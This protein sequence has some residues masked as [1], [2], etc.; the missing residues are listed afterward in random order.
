MPN[1][2]DVKRLSAMLGVSPR[3]IQKAIASGQVSARRR[4]GKSY[5]VDMDSLPERWRRRLGGDADLPALSSVGT[6]MRHG[7]P[8]SDDVVSALGRPLD[9]KEKRVY[10]IYQ[11]WAGQ[12]AMYSKESQRVAVTAAW[13]GVSPSTVRRAVARVES[14]GLISPS[15]PR[16]GSRWDPRAEAYLKG[17][18]LQ[19][20]KDRNID[21]KVAAWR[22]V[23]EKSVQEGWR[24]GCR[25]SAYR[26]LSAIPSLVMEYATGGDRA[27]DNIFY[28]RRDWSALKPAQILIGDQHRVDF[29][30]K[31]MRQDGTWRYYRPEFYVWEDA[32]SRCVAGLAVA[33]NYSSATVKD[34]LHMAVRRFGLFGCTYNDNGSS[35]CSEVVTQ[36]IDEM[37]ALSKG[38]SRMMDI[39]E[40]YRTKED[41]YVVEDEDGNVIDTAPDSRTWRAK[42]R[43]IYANVKNAKAKPI[44][45]LFNTLETMMAQAGIPGHVVDPTAPAHVEEKQ[46]L[47]L[48]RQKEQDEILTLDEFV[49]AM[50]ATIDRYEHARHSQLGCSPV[51]FVEKAIEDGWR[52]DLPA[53]PAD[54]DFVFLE[55]RKVLVTK[56][57]VTVNRIQYMGQDLRSTGSGDLEDVGIHLYEGTRIE[58]R[59]D[60]LDPD[61]AWAV[62]PHT[63]SPVR[64]LRRVEAVEM[65]DEEAMQERIEWKRRSMK[66]VRQAF[67]TLAYPERRIF[68][69][70]ISSQVEQADRPMVEQE[71]REALEKVRRMMEAPVEKEER[72]NVVRFFAS[73]RERFHWCLR[74]LIEGRTL[75]EGS[76]RFVQE[77]R[78]GDEYAQEKEY[79]ATYE[80]FG[81]LT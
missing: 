65:L 58:V 54:L 4:D 28:I 16:G 73:S 24:I 18:Y 68:E 63:D 37:I 49:Y 5:E 41:L 43:R 19:L 32:A 15:R 62:I 70:G 27:L 31:E 77:Y 7:M 72:R 60:P 8:V 69:T 55:R 35:E 6:L 64:A 67:R 75:D 59:F 22:A 21:S 30:V 78:T 79:W 14:G 3:A 20:L 39:S 26:L 13:F 40:L 36:I 50:V 42:H 47:V 71:R 52:A 57:R 81:G 1:W 2:T 29:W 74:E 44:E 10:E 33:E 17:Y 34:A 80:K 11:Y 51:Q 61:R 45:R 53:N 48:E 25:A 76:M 9:A 46:S 38:R 23:C 56:G 12:K 66:L